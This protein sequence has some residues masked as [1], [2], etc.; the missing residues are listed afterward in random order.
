[1]SLCESNVGITASPS[2]TNRL[3]KVPQPVTGLAVS[4]VFDLDDYWS[5]DH[6][7]VSNNVPSH[8]TEFLTLNK[9]IPIIQAARYI[10]LLPRVGWY[11]AESSD[12]SHPRP[13]S[14]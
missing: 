3:G 4:A 12:G 11:N 13:Q 8:D 1:M 6:V 2:T 9:T 5:L 14:S 10:R 7:T